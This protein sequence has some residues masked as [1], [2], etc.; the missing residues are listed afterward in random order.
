MVDILHKYGY[1]DVLP[2]YKIIGEKL[3][4]FLDKKEIAA[5]NYIPNGPQLL[6]RGSQLTPLYIK[7]FVKNLTEDFF[8]FRKLSLAEAKPKL[9]K[10][11][12]NIWQYFLPR[13]FS[14]FFYA[15]NNENPGKPI[16]RIFFDIDKS[17]IKAKEAQKVALSL[18]KLIKEDK[19]FNSL[20]KYKIFPMWTGKSFHIYL[21]LNKKV[22][23]SFYEKYIQ[24]SKNE[25]L[26]TF[27]GQW[28]AK[29]KEELKINVIGGHER[30]PN[31]INIDPSQ[32]PSGKLARAPF[33]LHMKD[34]KTI[35]GIAI[36]L[37]EKD[38]ESKNLINE[39]KN[40]NPNNVLNK[41]NNL[42]K[43]FPHLKIVTK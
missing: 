15:T 6:K 5:K 34:A 28:A 21:L 26:L 17:N 40:Y 10:V 25:P 4:R 2:Y 24:Y 12:T 30:K 7:D 27:T 23:N 16:D 36:P 38:L 9:N 1:L 43:K 41:L 31:T 19:E 39:F 22:P 35:D 18:I 37:T 13:K 11:Q 3:V 32:T 42:A 20:V 33:S 29:I 14:D 8:E